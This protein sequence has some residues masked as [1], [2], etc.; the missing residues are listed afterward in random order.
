MR[1]INI[2]GIPLLLNP[3]FLLLLGG[4]AL[5]GFLREAL[6][7]FTIVSLHEGAHALVARGLGLQVMEIELFP[8][9][10]VARLEEALELDP[11]AEKHVALAGPLFNFVLAGGALALYMNQVWVSEGLLFFVRLNLIL[12]FF[13]LLPALPL[14]GGRILRAGLAPSLGFQKA[15]AF[16]LKLS[17]ALALALLLA[18]G[19]LLF[20]DYRDIS[21]IFA[22]LFLLYAVHKENKNFM[23]QFVRYLVRKRE[24]MEEKGALPAA[25]IVAVEDASLKEI[26]H[27]FSPRKYHLILVLDRSMRVL[28]EVSETEIIEKVLQEGIYLR[29]K[30]LLK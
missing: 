10:G 4:A 20:L 21:L 18:G 11:Q 30:K 29:I 13:N 25:Y 8:F 12:G 27:L 17:R 2:G 14:D 1:V 9:G 16:S 24:D 28:G 22:G 23:F 6:I 26:L 19:L 7:L 5:G 15:T 3:F